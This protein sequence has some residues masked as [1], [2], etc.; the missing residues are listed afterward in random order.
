MKDLSE[1]KNKGY[2]QVD[3]EQFD[4]KVNAI[5]AAQKKDTEVTFHYND[6]WWNQHNWATEPT[7][8]LEEL[9]VKRAKQLR[10]KYKTLILRYSGGSDSNNIIRTFLDNNIKIDVVVINDYEG[11]SSTPW[12]DHAGNLERKLITWPTV[13]QFLADG[14]N[15]ELLRVD[16]SFQ[17]LVIRDDPEWIFKV[18]APRL[19][20]VEITA[21]R[22]GLSETLSKYNNSDTC[23]ISGLDKPRVQLLNN[24][25][26][27]SYIPDILPVLSDPGHSN[28]I[29]EPFYWTADL[30][31][32]HIK[33]CHAVK[34]WANNNI[35]KLPENKCI[36]GTKN[37]IIPL[38][39]EKYYD[40]T[41]GDKLPY[42]DT[43]C[44]TKDIP[45]DN[46][47]DYNIKQTP[48]YESHHQ[49]VSLADSL[50]DDRFKNKDSIWE[51]GLKFIN[52]KP[53][54]LGK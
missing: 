33:Q 49:V 1:I 24:K 21:S 20:M 27:M 40:F 23:I 14:A 6:R 16:T 17:A 48:I 46:V 43:L 54:W 39:Y 8:S 38:I 45:Y 25:I 2:W 5:L 44:F 31:E 53:R 35:N 7:D 51:N 41:P 32:L 3:G 9:Y 12:E 30:P 36:F 34:N 50:I 15:F 52:T 28:M 4:V 37:L 13:Q 26:W 47:Q 11:L 29:Q 42:F 19:R 18:N 22:M 10:S